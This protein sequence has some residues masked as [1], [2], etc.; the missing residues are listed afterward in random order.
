VD[1]AVLAAPSQSHVEIAKTLLA[2]N[3]HLLV[4]KPIAQTTAGSMAISQLARQRNLV[5]MAGYQLL[6]HPAY[7]QLKLLFKADAIGAVRHIDAVRT[8]AFSLDVDADVFDAFLSHDASMMIDLLG[9]SPE[10]ISVNGIR[11]DAYE[12]VMAANIE[13]DFPVGVKA[14]I[15]LAYRATE[16]RRRLEVIGDKG[17]LV[18]EDAGTHSELLWICGSKVRHVSVS[19]KEPLMCEA[20]HFLSCIQ[21]GLTP[22]SGQAHFN[23]VTAVIEAAR[24]TGRSLLFEL[25]HDLPEKDQVLFHENL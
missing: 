2:K 13:L 17:S 24:Q 6:F 15:E 9:E 16:K 12:R 3:I 14:H 19:R 8:G 10:A 20:Q 5:L 1:A 7:Q 25:V 23:S 22:R 21:T 11:S 18:F 4:E